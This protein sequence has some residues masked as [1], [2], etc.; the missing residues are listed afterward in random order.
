MDA[1][2]AGGA[3]RAT[4]SAR[5]ANLTKSQTWLFAGGSLGT[6]CLPFVFYMHST[7]V[8]VTFYGAD[9]ITIGTVGVVVGI[10]NVINGLPV[11]S[12]ADKGLLNAW[13]PKRFAME[14]WGRRAPWM[15]LGLPSLL[16]GAVGMWLC[17]SDAS[18]GAAAA[19]YALCY[20]CMVNGMTAHMQS[21]LASIQELWP[22]ARERAAAVCRQAPFVTLSVLVAVGAVPMLAFSYTPETDTCCVTPNTDCALKPP[23]V[24]FVNGT[25]ADGAA[26]VARAN[27]GTAALVPA[28]AAH[29]TPTDAARAEFLA[30]LNLGD[31]LGDVRAAACDAAASNDR[32]GAAALLVLAVG[33]TGFLALPAARRSP[34]R[35]PAAPAGGDAENSGGGG[36]ALSL[37]AAVR[38]TFGSDAFRWYTA[39]MFLSATFGGMISSHIGP[40][41]FRG[42]L[43]FQIER[44]L[45]LHSYGPL[46]PHNR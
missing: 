45:H 8:F 12:A 23:C 3:R 46:D 24:C 26:A 30:A 40:S 16:L 11:A 28:L 2:G 21:Y 33:V 32:F 20:F 4:T 38:R 37:V 7:L 35:P 31:A 14:R 42:T 9:A 27:A 19:W 39:M 13:F 25:M 5:R 15:V 17:P 1:P 22:T 6:W 41:K 36:K 29:C 18:Q 44:P 10:W 43:F 34:V